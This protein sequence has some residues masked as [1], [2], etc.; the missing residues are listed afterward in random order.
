MSPSLSKP[1]VSIIVACLLPKYGIGYNGQLPW[2]LKKEMKYFRDI[3]TKTQNPDKKNVLIMGRKTWESIPT[4]FRPLPGRINIVLTRNLNKCREDLKEELERVNSG[5]GSAPFLHICDSL[6][7]ALD[8]IEMS[9]IEEVFIIG[10][11]EIY[12]QL[13]LSN[14][15]NID[16]L[17]LTEVKH[18]DGESVDIPLDSFINIDKT[19]WSKSSTEALS[20]YLESKGL[21]D[22]FT[23]TG[24]EESD[25][26]YDFTLWEKK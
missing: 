22:S 8:T 24:N 14:S 10:G 11:A 15:K 7:N 25:F 20:E 21:K 3:T 9:A 1:K 16:Q 2:R 26:V 23:L 12:N 6:S 18:K 19:I 17:L 5:T 4:K 13:L